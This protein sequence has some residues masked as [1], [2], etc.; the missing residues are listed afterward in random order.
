[1]VNGFK[2]SVYSLLAK[3]DFVGEVACSN[4]HYSLSARVNIFTI[5]FAQVF[6]S[7]GFPCVNND[8]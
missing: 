1:M 5:I 3:K 6:L 2:Y 8:T 7:V 4:N